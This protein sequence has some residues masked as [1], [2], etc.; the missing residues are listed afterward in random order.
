LLYG[1]V[2]VRRNAIPR[3]NGGLSSCFS[4]LRCRNFS[5]FVNA[6]EQARI[7]QTAGFKSEEVAA[8]VEIGVER[9]AVKFTAGNEGDGLAAKE[10]VVRILRMQADGIGVEVCSRR[11]NNKTKRVSILIL[12]ALL[13]NN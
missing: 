5:R 9:G 1:F 3:S 4:S 12:Q 13:A 7:V 6:A 2:R 8:I 11:A 10:K